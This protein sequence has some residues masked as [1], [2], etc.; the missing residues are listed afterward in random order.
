MVKKETDAAKEKEP[1][2]KAEEIKEEKKPKAETK[3]A[4]PK[5]K[6][7]KAVKEADKKEPKKEDEKKS[8]Q[9][10]DSKSKI[11]KKTEDV[12][13]DAPEDIKKRAEEIE[14]KL[15]SSGERAEEGKED[16]ADKAETQEPAPAGKKG[17]VKIFSSGNNTIIHITDITGAETISRVSGGMV[18][19]Q[20]RL[21]GAPFQA[22]LAANRSIDEALAA[23]ITTIDILVRAPGGHKELSVGKGA[24]QAIKAFSKSRLKIGFVEDVT[25]II[26]GTMRRKGGRRGRRL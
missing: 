9:K 4:E 3:K 26:H 23:G 5:E 2:A 14:A 19:K 6:P 25:P 13:T 21:K 1:K 17:V 8:S 10:K 24:E 12:P 16:K 7:A 22:M 15:S 18:T 20:D 11:S